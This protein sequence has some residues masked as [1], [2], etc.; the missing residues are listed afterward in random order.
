[1][2]F[3]LK[4][5]V[6]LQIY[7]FTYIPHMFLSHAEV[8]FEFEHARDIVG[9]WMLSLNLDTLCVIVTLRTIVSTEICNYGQLFFL[10]KRFEVF[11]GGNHES[12]LSD[13]LGKPVC[14]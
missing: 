2:F 12:L 3:S 9:I 13:R 5:L 11:I 10:L 6:L 8:Y 1:M 7:R 4:N 14:V